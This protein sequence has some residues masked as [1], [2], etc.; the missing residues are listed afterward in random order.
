MSA[1]WAELIAWYG[2]PVL[3]LAAGWFARA[4]WEQPRRNA[5]EQALEQ[6]RLELRT[7]TAHTMARHKARSE[8]AVRGHATRRG[9]GKAMEG[10]EPPIVS[11]EFHP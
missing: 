5:T 2:V 1:E 7:L 8:A 10:V 6:A 11:L 4:V 3:L 9:R